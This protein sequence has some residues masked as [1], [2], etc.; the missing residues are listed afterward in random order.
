MISPEEFDEIDG[1]ECVTLI[2]YSDGVL[3][4]DAEE[5]IDDVEDIVGPDALNSF[6]RYEDDAVHVRNN[7][8]KCD[9]EILKDTRC[10][11][12][13]RRDRTGVGE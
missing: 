2:Y 3:V 6:G 13:I 9:Y 5:I 1:Y 10:Y 12:D 11:S 8:L 7:R 4:D